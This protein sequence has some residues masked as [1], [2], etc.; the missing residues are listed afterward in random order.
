M[1]YNMGYNNQPPVIEMREQ[2]EEPFRQEQNVGSF[3][4]EQYMQSSRQE[5]GQ[6]QFMQPTSQEQGQFIEP[7]QHEQYVQA[8]NSDN[9]FA[10]EQY[11]S[12]SI[13]D[14]PSSGASIAEV[15][16]FRTE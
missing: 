6:G 2:H 13:P 8:P 15:S 12:V 4:Q 16:L 5:Q 10:A 7:S 1:E 9:P 3:E 11:K 14:S